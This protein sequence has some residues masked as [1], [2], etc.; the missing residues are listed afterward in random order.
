MPKAITIRAA[1]V[2]MLAVL[3]AALLAAGRLALQSRPPEATAVAS[4]RF[5]TIGVVRVRAAVASAKIISIASSVEIAGSRGIF[6]SVTAQ[7]SVSSQRRYVA[8]VP[9]SHRDTS[10][11]D[12]HK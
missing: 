8:E 3:A 7:G 6:G 12:M 2:V 5:A 4:S 1:V 10:Q 9:Q 11:L